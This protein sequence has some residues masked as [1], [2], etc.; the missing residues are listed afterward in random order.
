MFYSYILKSLKDGKY[1]YG[2]AEDLDVRLGKHN[3]WNVRSTKGRRPLV[4]HYITER[5]QSGR[6]SKP[7]KFVYLQ[8]YR[9]FESLPLRN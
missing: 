9:G 4:L 5:C 2:C 1:H 3:K 8:G 7:G 6:M